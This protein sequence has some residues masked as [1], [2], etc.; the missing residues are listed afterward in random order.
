MREVVEVAE[1]TLETP[2]TVTLRFDYRPGAERG[3]S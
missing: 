1:R 3:S 2:S